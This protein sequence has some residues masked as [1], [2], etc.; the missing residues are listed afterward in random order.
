LKDGV[1][2]ES[3]SGTPQ[4]SPISPVLANVALH[5]LDAA[6]A[7]TSRTVGVLVRYADDLVV[8]CTSRGNAEEARRRVTTMLEP[9][10]LQL[11]PDKT[12]IVCLT[13]GQQGFDFLGFH[14]RKVES[15]RWRGHYYLQRWPSDR[16][17]SSIRSKVR[18]VT[19]QRNVGAS[20]EMVVA[21]LNQV[22]RGWAGYFRHGSSSRKFAIIDRYVHERLAMLDSI[23][24]GRRGRKWR[25]HDQV[26]L[27]RLGV[28]RL[29][30]ST[31]T[32]T[33]HA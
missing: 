20:I 1:T 33:A 29:S 3:E 11:H 8:L 13:R 14:Q 25:H 23:K 18:Q 27:E 9:L 22:V 26:W 6:W 4:G 10:G 28:Y 16:A 17:M 30:R 5:V 21:K 32:G 7:R 2:T 31:R 12:R 19:D 24:H 15:W